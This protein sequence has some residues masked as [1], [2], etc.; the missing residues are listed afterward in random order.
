[1]TQ[2]VVAD[3]GAD[4]PLNSKSKPNVIVAADA[5]DTNPMTSTTSAPISS[6]RHWVPLF[7]EVVEQ[8][9]L[10]KSNTALPTFPR[11]SRVEVTRRFQ[12]REPEPNQLNELSPIRPSQVLPL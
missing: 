7:L 1:V 12:R 3:A 6:G 5:P 2:G 10:S 9:T 8:E 4:A 11:A